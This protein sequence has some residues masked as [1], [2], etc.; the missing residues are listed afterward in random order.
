MKNCIFISFLN[1][2]TYLSCW[3]LASLDSLF[4]FSVMKTFGWAMYKSCNG[5]MKIVWGIVIC[6][7]FTQNINK[8]SNLN[9]KKPGLSFTSGDSKFCWSLW[10]CCFL[11]PLMYAKYH[12]GPDTSL[13]ICAYKYSIPNANKVWVYRIHPGSMEIL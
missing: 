1:H 3:A 8:E 12:L 10:P 4:K 2:V 5:N 9:I 7:I 6:A 13:T 11:R